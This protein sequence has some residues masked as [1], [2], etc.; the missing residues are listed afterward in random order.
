MTMPRNAIAVLFLISGAAFAL[1]DSTPTF[2]SATRLVEVDVV[3]RSKGAP[4]KGLTKEDFTV[5][6]NGKQQNI[7]FFSIRSPRGARSASALPPLP[8]GAVS[9]RLERDGPLLSRATILL[10][11]QKNTP[12]DAQAFAIQRIKTFVRTSR[13]GDRLGIYS[14]GKDGEFHPVQELTDDS[15]L[16]VKAA[17]TLKAMDPNYR[18]Q[19]TTGM[20][21]HA[22]QAYSTETVLE[23]VAVTKRV[24]MTIARHLANMP[25]RKNLIWITTAFPHATEAA[26]FTP[27]IEQAAR[28]LNDANIA[29]YPVDARGLIGALQGLSPIPNAEVGGPASPRQLIMQAGRGTRGNPLRGAD[30]EKMFADLT[31]GLAFMNKS[32]AIEESMQSAVDDGELTYKLGFYPMQDDKDRSWH[33]LKIAVDRRGVSLRY[34]LNYL[35][36][37]VL[38]T[39]NEAPAREALLQ[40]PLDATQLEIIAEATPDHVQVT[41]DLHD[42]HL[43]KQNDT[44]VGG[45]DV[46]FFA[47]GSHTA[48]T[49]T[50]KLEIPDAE[51]AAA[52]E[53]GVVVNDSITA[54]GPMDTLRIVA[55]DRATGAAGSLR[56]RLSPKESAATAGASEASRKH[57][58]SAP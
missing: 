25:G 44:W 28:A 1:Q 50:R 11:D 58:T 23:Q 10:V 5:F 12:Q 52:L 32:N 34:R 57:G 2:R 22:A 24:L 38:T 41:V 47:E 31:G 30:T 37:G 6:D 36:S 45:V 9:N 46:T 8:A 20:S 51:L 18:T 14:F 7:A 53:K 33:D 27:D 3:T 19:D 4:A 13:K 35:A 39:A 17:N 16:L 55:Q 26:D 29:L 21:E 40:D 43:E 54:D 48:R 42:I 49:I 15:Q 56:I